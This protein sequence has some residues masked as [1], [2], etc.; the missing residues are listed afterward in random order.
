MHAGYEL[1]FQT[2]FLINNTD[3][4]YSYS[5]NW[6]FT[7]VQIEISLNATQLCCLTLYCTVCALILDPTRF[8]NCQL[9]VQDSIDIVFEIP[10][11]PHFDANIMAK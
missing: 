7:Q 6:P 2:I 10:K 3:H 11:I 8:P 5:C 1:S 4:S 9:Q